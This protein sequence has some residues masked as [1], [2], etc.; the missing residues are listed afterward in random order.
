MSVRSLIVLRGLLV[1]ALLQPPFVECRCCSP[2]SS[3]SRVAMITE[4]MITE[5]MQ[6][7]QLRAEL[8]LIV[9]NCMPIT[10]ALMSI[11]MAAMMPMDQAKQGKQ[12]NEGRDAASDAACSDARAGSGAAG[13]REQERERR[14]QDLDDPNPNPNPNLNPN[15]ERERRLASEMPHSEQQDRLNSE[16]PN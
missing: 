7:K 1:H 4:A 14:E 8:K 13:G 12:D 6:R 5:S 16:M 2:S 15:Q 11:T 3:S 9:L 10:V